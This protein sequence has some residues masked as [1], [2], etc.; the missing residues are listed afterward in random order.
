MKSTGIVRKI[1]DLGRIVVP[2]E[3]R[4][5][6]DIKDGDPLEIFMD[7]NLI[8]LKAYKPG[9]HECGDEGIA[10]YGSRVKLCKPCIQS[11]NY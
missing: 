5:I 7:G 9:C 3:I 6:S 10:L 1:D 4:R 8:V 11:F 2:K